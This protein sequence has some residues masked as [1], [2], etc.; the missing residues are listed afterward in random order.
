MDD[1][2]VCST[3]GGTGVLPEFNKKARRAFDLNKA[4][5][6]A[7]MSGDLEEAEMLYAQAR[8]IWQN[9]ETETNVR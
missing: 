7:E 1:D 5:R 9:Y 4:G 2:Q 3:C 8:A 6:K